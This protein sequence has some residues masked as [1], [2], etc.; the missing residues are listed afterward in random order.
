MYLTNVFKGAALTKGSLRRVAVGNVVAL[1]TVS[2]FT[3]I[4]SE[5][6]TAV[7]P[8]YLVLGLHLSLISYGVLDG[9]YTG[10]TAFT[11]L[12]GGYL[13]DRLSRRSSSPDSATGC[14]RCPRSDSC[15]PA[16]PPWPSAR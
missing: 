8:A 3:D 4:S 10:A 9:L 14:P 13:A 2:L 12:V 1:G 15:W 6:V 7:L 16:R 5:M 11:R